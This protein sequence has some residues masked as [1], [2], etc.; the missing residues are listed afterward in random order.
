MATAPSSTTRSRRPARPALA[1]PRWRS[2]L[3]LGLCFG[4]G[5]G[6]TQRLLAL[7]WADDASRPPA[8]RATSPAEGTSLD[9]LRR[10]HGE[11]KQ[12]LPADLDTL[13]RQKR[14]AQQKQ[15]AAKREEAER[16]KAGP[17]EEKDQLESERRRLEEFNRSPDSPDL[18]PT[19]QGGVEGATPLA[20][21][22]PPPIPSTT[23]QAPSAPS[24]SPG[25][26]APSLP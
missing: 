7:H 2:W 19:G 21:E 16:Q 15:E 20:P 3:V 8:F 13:A 25:Q 6:I 9:D 24:Q 26:P 5:H 23:D 14:E 18:Q 22:L 12:P 11:S 10:Q 17:L 4:L 1:P